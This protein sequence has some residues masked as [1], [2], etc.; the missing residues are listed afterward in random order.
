M[1]F[2]EGLEIETG[3]VRSLQKCLC[4]H[5]QRG[6][7]PEVL[8][9]GKEF[10]GVHEA[11]QM[12]LGLVDFSFLVENMKRRFAVHSDSF[13]WIAPSKDG[14]LLATISKDK[15]CKIFDVVNFGFFS[16]L[17]LSFFSFFCTQPLQLQ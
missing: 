7:A 13:Q 6:W 11:L 3:V 14:L 17:F 12:P 4:D 9:E 8:A 15:S 10:S 2:C 16:L 1:G 5:C